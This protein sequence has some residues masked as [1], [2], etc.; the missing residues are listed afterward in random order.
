MTLTSSWYLGWM[1]KFYSSALSYQ[2]T[3]ARARYKTFLQYHNLV[4]NRFNF[5][6]RLHFI[7]THLSNHRINYVRSNRHS[8]DFYVRACVCFN[9]FQTPPGRRK[10]AKNAHKWAA[11]TP[12]VNKKFRCSL[13]ER[14]LRS[15]D[16]LMICQTGIFECSR[17]FSE[18]N[19]KWANDWWPH[20]DGMRLM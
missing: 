8:I 18:Y 2:G 6:Q 15:H 14:K 17:N 16:C 19:Q 11:L 12:L 7:R 20:L 13:N 5:Y 3:D 4:L 9:T 1:I 10:L